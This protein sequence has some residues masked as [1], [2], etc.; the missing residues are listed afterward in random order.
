MVSKSLVRVL[1]YIVNLGGISKLF[2]PKRALTKK[3]LPGLYELPGGHIN[4]G[5]DIV[6]GLRREVYEEL[7]MTLKIGDPF[8][9]FT[10][11]NLIKGS[12][13]IEVIYFAQFVEP[14][15]H[16]KIN[17]EDHTTFDWFTRAEV[18][19]N[20]HHIIPSEHVSHSIE[21]DPEYLTM[22]RGFDL[23]SGSSLNFK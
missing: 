12:H 14:L 17:P 13:S 5:E 11:Q 9:A 20:K 15:D 16:I 19:E 8:A 23:L 2:L 1:L 22:L 6:E 18:V 21:T 10:Y 3:F 7:G 4:F